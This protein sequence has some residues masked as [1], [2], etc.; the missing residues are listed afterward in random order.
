MSKKLFI[1][2][3]FIFGAFLAVTTTSCGDKCKDVECNTGTCLD[4]TC[5]CGTGFEGENCEIEWSAKFIGSYLGQD[6]VTVSTAVPSNVGTY[7]LTS[8]A[9]VTRINESEIQIANFGGFN[10]ILK[11]TIEDGDHLHISYTDP[12]GRVFAGEGQLSGNTLSGSYRVTY[13]DAS[14]DDANFT[15]NK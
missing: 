1:L 15:Y 9:V 11:A 8:P 13:T 6:V 12:A 10:S 3:L 14:Y 4:G 7:N 5:E 2:P